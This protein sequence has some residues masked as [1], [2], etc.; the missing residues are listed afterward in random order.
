MLEMN[1]NVDFNKTRCDPKELIESYNMMNKDI[2]GLL[3]QALFAKRSFNLCE[4]YMF[5]AEES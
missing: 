3:S 5:L 1:K 4:L 2:Y